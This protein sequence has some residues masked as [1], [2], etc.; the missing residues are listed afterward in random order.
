MNLFQY[1][2]ELVKTRPKITKTYTEKKLVGRT[3]V[4]YYH[5]EYGAN[6]DRRTRRLDYLGDHYIDKYK[7]EYHTYDLVCTCV[8]RDRSMNSKVFLVVSAQ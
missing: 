6:G 7:T 1:W 8:S 5:T 4:E 3:L 2:N